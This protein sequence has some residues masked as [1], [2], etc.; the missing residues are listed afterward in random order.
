MCRS[1]VSHKI[2][3]C[4]LE[5]DPCCEHCHQQIRILIIGSKS[6]LENKLLLCIS[7][8]C[9]EKRSMFLWHFVRLHWT[10]IQIPAFS[11]LLFLDPTVLHSS[12]T[13]FNRVCLKFHFKYRAELW[14]ERRYSK[15]IYRGR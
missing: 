13:N 9:I 7:Q 10:I 2:I 8:G 14:V 15:P 6:A 11:M 3:W 12:G 5:D 4:F 1:N